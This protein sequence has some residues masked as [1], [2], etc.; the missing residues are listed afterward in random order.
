M[1]VYRNLFAEFIEEQRRTNERT[2]EY[3]ATRW[4]VNAGTIS[5]WARGDRRIGANNR[6]V[7]KDLPFTMDEY[8]RLMPPSDQSQKR[9]DVKKYGRTRAAAGVKS[10]IAQVAAAAGIVT[11]ANSAKR[12]PQQPDAET[13]AV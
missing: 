5:R 4:N 2:I 6:H 1:P 11:V 9:S 12:T 3:W 8:Y 7:F 10:S 13:I